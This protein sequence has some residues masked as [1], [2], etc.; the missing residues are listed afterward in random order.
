[1]TTTIPA[2]LARTQLGSLLKEVSRRKTRFVITKSGKATAV[3]LAAT[4]FDDMVEE[5]D[6]VF[7]K[8]LEIAKAESKVGKTITLQDYMRR[9]LKRRTG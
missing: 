1:M 8:S 9:H 2:Y 3:L 4:D 6:P 7:R 5:L